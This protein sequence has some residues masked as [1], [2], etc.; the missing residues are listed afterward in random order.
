[1]E[2]VF[3][4]IVYL[5]YGSQDQGAVLSVLLT[6][7]SW[8]LALSWLYAP[9]IFN[10]SGFEWQKYVPFPYTTLLLQFVFHY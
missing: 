1:M 6:Y 10:P 4:L 7:S 2:I 9:F 3:L 8:F 5:V